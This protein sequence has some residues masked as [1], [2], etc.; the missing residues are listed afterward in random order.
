MIK[1]LRTIQPF[2]CIPGRQIISCKKNHQKSS[3]GNQDTGLTSMDNRTPIPPTD[4][5]SLATEKD[6]VSTCI[7]SYRHLVT[8]LGIDSMWFYHRVGI[9]INLKISSVYEKEFVIYQY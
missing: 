9:P 3:K 5:T 7:F 8:T 4:C 6:L 1:S 2:A